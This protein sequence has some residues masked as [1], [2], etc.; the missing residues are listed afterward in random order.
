[1]KIITFYLPQY[2]PIPENDRWWGAGF[3]DW[4]N[5]KKCRPYFKNHYQPHEPG[6]L[7]YYDLRDPS[8]LE[9]QANLARAHGISAFCY[10]HYW[11][12][13]KLLLHQPLEEM[14]ASQNPD[15]PF[16]LCWAN[17]N[18]TRAW[19][20]MDKHIL[21][22]QKYSTADHEAHI[23]WLISVFN[24]KRYVKINGKPLFLLYRADRVPDLQ[25]TVYF[26]KKSVR[27]AGFP[28]LYFCAVQSNFPTCTGKELI[29]MG[30][31]SIVD[32]QP[33]IREYQRASLI[34]KLPRKLARW[35]FKFISRF[36]KKAL[37]LYY[38]FSAR[39]LSYQKMAEMVVRKQAACSC[40]TFS[41]V[42]PSWDC[43]ARIPD[44]VV[45]QNLSPDLYGQW[46]RQMGNRTIRRFEPEEQ[47]LFVNA[48]NE[49]AEG[50]HLEPDKRFGRA[51]L[52]ETKKVYQELCRK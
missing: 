36:Y 29:E 45:I 49:W 26:W 23:K 9:S 7:G 2:H 28:D 22:A 48:W 10:Y 41:C 12:N 42:F 37:P 40:K 19:D 11:F 50:C 16:C 17:E 6:D 24:D 46:L 47:I 27:S 20:G 1:L 33:N 18:W 31:D 34:N 21:I 3:T 5:V 30:F 44:A 43:S 52:E 15:F 38:Y 39:I 25:K 32:F 35:F 4:V 8:I 14:L 13:G 51:F